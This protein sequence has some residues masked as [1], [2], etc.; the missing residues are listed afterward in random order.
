MAPAHSSRR[1]LP[2]RRR[3]KSGSNTDRHARKHDTGGGASGSVACQQQQRRPEQQRQHRGFRRQLVV[4]RPIAVGRVRQLVVV[5]GDAAADA[6]RQQ[7]RPP[8]GH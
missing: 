5:A 2:R 3:R 7:G 8:D 4:G 1:S 6:A